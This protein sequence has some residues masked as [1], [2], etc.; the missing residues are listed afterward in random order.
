MKM[1]LTALQFQRREGQLP[2]PLPILHGGQLWLR[3][4]REGDRRG[5]NSVGLPCPAVNHLLV[6]GGGEEVQGETILFHGLDGDKLHTQLAL[7]EGKALLGILDAQRDLAHHR[8][9]PLPEDV[10]PA[11][12]EARPLLPAPRGAALEGRLQE[13]DLEPL[14]V[15]GVRQEPNVLELRAGP[16]GSS[17]ACLRQCRSCCVDVCKPK[18]DLPVQVLAR[19]AVRPRHGF[20]PSA[21]RDQLEARAVRA[22]GEP[23]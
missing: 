12:A 6:V 14:R 4:A 11:D 3:R 8:L 5:R 15:G 18:P 2:T 13:L 21:G 19:G 7:V 20:R 16:H 23:V 10:L 9:H 22:A 1:M 17:Q